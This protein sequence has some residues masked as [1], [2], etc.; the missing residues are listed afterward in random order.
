MLKQPQVSLPFKEYRSPGV[1][2]RELTIY[3]G[4]VLT[5]AVHK[6]E[7]LNILSQG[8]MR[9]L[10]EDGIVE[11][12]APFTVVSPPGT[13]RIAYAVT[14]CVWTTILGTDLTTTEEIEDYFVIKTEEEYRKWLSQSAQLSPEQAL[15]SLR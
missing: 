9:V 14:D 15:P 2:A 7:Q 8:T 10:T 12:S 3:A 4:C 5:G 6:Y 1:Y 11:V 13:K